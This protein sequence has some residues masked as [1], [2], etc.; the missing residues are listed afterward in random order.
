MSR[1]ERGG[2]PGSAA[3]SPRLGRLRM[4][5]EPVFLLRG[6]CSTKIATIYLT[7]QSIDKPC[8]RLRQKR[9]GIAGYL[10]SSEELIRMHILRGSLVVGMIAL[11]VGLIGAGAGDYWHV[12]S[13]QREA[14]LLGARAGRQSERRRL[15]R[16]RPR[17]PRRQRGRR[18][19]RRRDE[20]R[21]LPR[22]LGP[23]VGDGFQTADTDGTLYSSK[24]LQNYLELVLRERRRQPLGGRADAVLQRRAARLDE[25]RRAAPASSRTRRAS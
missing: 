17:L 4:R 21:R 7:D 1:T 8:L 22:L 3:P 25:L 11:L 24:T 13:H 15:G 9:V 19:D 14:L 6:D 5:P 18:R 23:G 16:E 20:A 12:H 2:R 10:S